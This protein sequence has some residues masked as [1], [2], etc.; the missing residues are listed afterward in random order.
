[1]LKFYVVKGDEREGDGF[2]QVMEFDTLSQFL[3]FADYNRNYINEIRT[4][5]GGE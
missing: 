3:R 1:M 2:A 4:L 5:E